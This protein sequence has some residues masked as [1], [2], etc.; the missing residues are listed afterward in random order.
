MANLD[1]MTMLM[2]SGPILLMGVRARDMV[3][4][5]NT[6][7]KGIEVLIFTTPVSLLGNV[8]VGG[9]GACTAAFVLVI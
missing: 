8:K 4:N 1:Y 6:L 2:L 5:T 3:R 9:S 7:K